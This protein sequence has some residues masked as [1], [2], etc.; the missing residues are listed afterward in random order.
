MQ[1]PE[2]TNRRDPGQH[3]A[4]ISKTKIRKKI[5]SAPWNKTLRCST[6]ANSIE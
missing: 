5:K 2:I 3:N 4:K 6:R 1:I